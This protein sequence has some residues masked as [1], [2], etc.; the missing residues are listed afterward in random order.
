MGFIDSNI[1]KELFERWH[2]EAAKQGVPLSRDRLLTLA[3]TETDGEVQLIV[4]A[5]DHIVNPPSK[6]GIPQ[7]SLRL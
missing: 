1:L 5:L 3:L 7:A 4:L 2:K 6:G